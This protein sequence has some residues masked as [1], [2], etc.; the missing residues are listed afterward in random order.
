MRDLWRVYDPVVWDRWAAAVMTVP[1][2]VPRMG[3]MAAIFG[4]LPIHHAKALMIVLILAQTQPLAVRSRWPA[5]C[6]A[7]VGV[8]FA[9]YGG[10][11]L[12]PE[13]G[14]V[15]LYLA[16]YSVGAHRPESD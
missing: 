5:A 1:A 4:D 11:G 6:L 16:L 8:S 10:F 15:A 2:F 9:V 12:P 7:M 14:N 13:F 3:S